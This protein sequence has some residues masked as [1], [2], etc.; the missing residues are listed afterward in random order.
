[1]K[2]LEAQ[3]FCSADLPWICA[4]MKKVTGLMIFYLAVFPDSVWAAFPILCLFETAC[5][6][7]ALMGFSGIMKDLI[8]FLTAGLCALS[9][10]KK[11]N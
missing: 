9:E 1:M 3:H 7:M 10:M 2:F 8:I 4:D 11:N 5:Q 6:A